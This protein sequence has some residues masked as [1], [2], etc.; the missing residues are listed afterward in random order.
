M[1]TEKQPLLSDPPAYSASSQSPG[2]Q[3]NQQASSTANAQ[4]LPPQ[5]LST[6]SASSSTSY[7]SSAPH[8]HVLVLDSTESALIFC[9]FCASNVVTVVE[10]PQD[11]LAYLTSMFLCLTAIPLCV[12]VPRC[13]PRCKEAV[14]RCPECR[15]CLAVVPA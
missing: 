9:P 3:Q 15:L 11:C 8:G 1:A 13:G 12:H 2:D 5:P 6:A 14:H 7:Q 4:A 10:E